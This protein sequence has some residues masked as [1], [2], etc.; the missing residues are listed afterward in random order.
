MLCELL[1]IFVGDFWLTLSSRGAILIE[2]RYKP[3]CV[4]SKVICGRSINN[5][6]I[7][8]RAN[9]IIVYTTTLDR[10]GFIRLPSGAFVRYPAL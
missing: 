10:K 6:L 2:L 1:L 3:I 5:L 8:S 4:D 9:K 7:N